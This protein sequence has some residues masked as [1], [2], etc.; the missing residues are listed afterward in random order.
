M[1]PEAKTFYSFKYICNF[2]NIC[3][4]PHAEVLVHQFI[5][6][7]AGYLEEDYQTFQTKKLHWL[8]SQESKWEYENYL[9]SINQ[10]LLNRKSIV[11]ILA[12]TVW[13]QIKVV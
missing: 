3:L 10:K 1:D 8:I 7:T 4:H 13:V 12:K 11:F 9:H 2:I 6:G 5:H